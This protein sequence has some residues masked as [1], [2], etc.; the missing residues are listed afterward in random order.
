L[1]FNSQ[2]TPKFGGGGTESILHPLVVAALILAVIAI[3]VL[4]RNRVAFPVLGIAFLVPLGQQFYV[5]GVHLFVLRLVLLIGLVRVFAGPRG[6]QGKRLAGGWS[7]IDTICTVLIMCQVVGVMLKYMDSQAVINQVGYLW[8]CLGAYF[9]FRALIQDE[10]DIYPALKF[11]AFLTA[12][13][14]VGMVI[15][16]AKMVN[17][18]GLLHGGPPEVPELREGRVRAQGVFF[19]PLTAGAY[20]AML[21]PLFVLLWKSGKAKIVAML[22]LT[23]A[24]I[25]TFST[26]TSTSVMSFAAAVAAILA[27][28]IRKNM[29][30]VRLGV[31]AA[32]VLLNFIMTSPVWWI[33][34]H[35]DLTGSSSSYQRALLVDKFIRNF[36]QWWLIGGSSEGWGWDMWDAQNQYVAVGLSGGLAGIVMFIALLSRCFGRI[37]KSLK[38]ATSN[39]EQWLYWLLG[40][41]LFVNMVAFFGV[42]YFDQVRVM[43][44]VLLAM[45]A[46]TTAARQPVV[47][48]HVE[49]EG[50]DF[51]LTHSEPA[52][53][54]SGW[55]H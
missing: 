2:L 45:I 50:D 36:S 48:K 54:A 16:Q 17:L 1:N 51:V 37:G 47:A 22:G 18:F 31:V 53:E 49:V 25:M 24:T 6:A 42:N 29:R 11:L 3:F 41:A 44:F 8:D 12:I 10:A 5:A 26:Q 30:A 23:A 55:G 13:L 33:I 32:L 19:H 9:L 4:P 15:E 43:W 28:P 27:W 39:Q 38:K 52:V 21:V 34:G 35:I 14:A 7:G 46:A 20:A 40:A